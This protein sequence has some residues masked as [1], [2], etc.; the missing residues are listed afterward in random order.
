MFVGGVS[1]TYDLHLGIAELINEKIT[2]PALIIISSISVLANLFR[3]K[4]ERHCH[5]RIN[6][7]ELRAFKPVGF[8]IG[9]DHVHNHH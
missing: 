4:I 2:N 1:G 5:N 3:N 8:A 6:G 9:R 7:Q